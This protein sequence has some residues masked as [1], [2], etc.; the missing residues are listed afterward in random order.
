MRYEKIILGQIRCEKAPQVV[1]ACVATGRRN[2]NM[3]Q[4]T[5]FHISRGKRAKHLTLTSII[6]LHFESINDEK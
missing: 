1:R 3:V 4:P 2:F 6:T 5:L